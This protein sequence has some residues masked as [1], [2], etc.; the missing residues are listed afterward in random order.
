MTNQS[1]I[2]E[3]LALRSKYSMLDIIVDEYVNTFCY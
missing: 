3:E 2:S 1:M